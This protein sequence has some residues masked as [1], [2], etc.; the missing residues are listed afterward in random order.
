MNN[1]ETD[2][3]DFARA[4][5]FALVAAAAGLGVCALFLRDRTAVMQAYLLAFL[6][7]M[8]LTL[9]SLSLLLLQYV[10]GGRWG[11]TIRRFLEAA[12]RMLPLM[13]VL[14]IP[15]VLQRAR[16]Y[17]WA[18]P[19]AAADHLIQLKVAYLN[20]TAWTVRAAVYFIVWIAITTAVV[21]LSRRQDET[22]TPEIAGKLRSI[23]APSLVAYA[24]T[25]SFAAF[26]WGMS[27]EPHWFSTIYGVL[28]AAGGALGA[29]SLATVV[30][31]RVGNRA[32]FA[33]FLKGETVGDLGNLTLAFTMFWTYI[34]LSQMLII[35]SGH[36][37][38]ETPWYFSRFKHGWQY[39]CMLLFGLQFALTFLLL[40]FRDRKRNLKRLWRVSLFVLVM[41]SVDLFWIIVPAFSPEHLRVRVVDV[42]ALVGLGGVWF[43][44]YL[45][46]L[47][48]APLLPVRLVE[49][50][51]K[52]GAHHG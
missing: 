17:P 1:P 28:Y 38:E 52:G 5:R 49:A 22:D 6:Y 23:S 8:A 50:E 32:P 21:R 47:A 9:G 14:F 7:W 3:P 20:G 15:I 40:L 16:L 31:S 29:I 25:V 24:L 33:T 42:A 13:A 12:A 37:P 30:L 46:A 48:S 26:D 35:W 4:Q 19:E 2:R 27:L 18:M 45:R 36:L 10:S 39:I 51:A 41:R 43:W 44:F 11:L 34:S